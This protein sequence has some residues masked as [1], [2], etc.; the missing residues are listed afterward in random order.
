V[1]ACSQRL[2]HGR[3]ARDASYGCFDEAHHHQLQPSNRT[4][5]NTAHM[6][7]SNRATQ[8]A[9]RDTRTI[10]HPPTPTGSAWS[11]YSQKARCSSFSPY[12]L[13]CPCSVGGRRLPDPQ[14]H[15]VNPQSRRHPRCAGRPQATGTSATARAAT[16]SATTQPPMRS[17]ERK[18]LSQASEATFSASPKNLGERD[19]IRLCQP[20]LTTPKTPHLP[21]RT[22]LTKI[23]SRGPYGR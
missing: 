23:C 15:V 18:T 20:A 10:E 4:A 14:H 19:H 11:T 13:H 3:E 17:F 9:L 7:V 22:F 8:T 1:L 21:S 12:P 16:R 2:N 5:H 6:K